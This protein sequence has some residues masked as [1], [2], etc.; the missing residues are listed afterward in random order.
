MRTALVCLIQELST[1]DADDANAGSFRGAAGYLVKH[2][3]RLPLVCF[4]YLIT[5]M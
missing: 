5:Y 3:P 1:F 4:S 2:V